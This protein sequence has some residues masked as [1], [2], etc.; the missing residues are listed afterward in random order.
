MMRKLLAL[1]AHPDDESFGFAGTLA[2]YAREGVEV[3]VLCATRG[4][5]GKGDG[6]VGKTREQELLAASKILGVA[7]VDFLDFQ[8]GTL[9]NNLY[10]KL[11]EG[12]RAKIDSFQPDVIL[13][14]EYRGVSGH[15]DHVTVS[16]VT[17]FVLRNLGRKIKL[18]HLV[19]HKNFAR[20]T[21]KYFVFFPPGFSDDQIDVTVDIKDTWDL[22]KKAMRAH[23]SQK[24]DADRI[25]L[26]K[27]FLPK[28]EYFLAIPPKNTPGS[29]TDLFDY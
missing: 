8:D 11:A 23:I 16:L 14:Y 24:H 20:F 7:K 29:T 28:K 6:D 13:T 27:R 21:G 1:I 5:K 10:H 18:F 2:K 12:F 9:S 19:E 15:L 17:S 22:K 4:E 3:H 25:L 26:L